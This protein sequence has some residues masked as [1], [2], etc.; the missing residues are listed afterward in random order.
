MVSDNQAVWST[1]P[2]CDTRRRLRCPWAEAGPGRASSRHAQPHVSTPGPTGVEGAGRTGGGT[3]GH[4]RASRRHT[5]SN[6]D[7]TATKRVGIARHEGPTRRRHATKGL[8][9]VQTPHR[10]G[11]GGSSNASDGTHP[12]CVPRL[13]RACSWIRR[14][15]VNPSRAT[16]PS[17][18]CSS[19][20]ARRTSAPRRCA[21][22]ACRMSRY[23]WRPEWTTR[24]AR[25]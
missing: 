23:A 25:S 15:S 10:R 20:P 6:R 16:I 22:A 21:E 24:D 3:G 18:P 12:S 14:T 19:C 4:W 7:L 8:H 5:T 2:R 9:V 17:P 13:D 11:Y 1:G